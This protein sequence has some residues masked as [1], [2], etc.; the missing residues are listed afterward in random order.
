MGERVNLVASFVDATEQKRL[1]AQLL[2]AQK[3]ESV[4][5]SPAE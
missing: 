5:V 3:M 4:G 2:H 1:E